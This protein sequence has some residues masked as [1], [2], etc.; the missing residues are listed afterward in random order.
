MPMLP[1]AV[2]QQPSPRLSLPAWGVESPQEGGEFLA[3]TMSILKVI[4]REEVSK[5]HQVTKQKHLRVYNQGLQ[6]SGCTS[7][8]PAKSGQL[9]LNPSEDKW[10]KL[11]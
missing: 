10:A 4:Q 3:C 11:W 9:P 1:L 6:G 5:F 2:Q 8:G 7:L